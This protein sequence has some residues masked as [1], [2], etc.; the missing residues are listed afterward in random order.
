MRTLGEKRHF[1]FK[2][3]NAFPKHILF[4]KCLYF[5]IREDLLFALYEDPAA[6]GASEAKDEEEAVEEVDE[7]AAA[8]GVVGV[9]DVDFVDETA[10]GGEEEEVGDSG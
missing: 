3:A 6:V 2:K 1:E 9:D 4:K 7:T 10:E 5:L 8:G